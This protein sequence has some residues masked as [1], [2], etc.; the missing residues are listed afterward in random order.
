[1]KIVID[2]DIPFSDSMFAGRAEVVTAP[3]EK[4]SPELVKTADVLIVRS[5]TRVDERLLAGSSVAFVGTAT[6]GF[7][8]VDRAYLGRRGIAFAHAPGCNADSVAEYVV[9]AL[10]E[11]GERFHVRLRGTTIGI[12]GAGHVGRRVARKA[13]ALGMTVLLNDPPLAA[14][15]GGAGFLDLGDLMDADFVS[16]HVPLTKS[17]PHP[18]HHLFDRRRIA[19]MRPGSFLLNT[20]RGGVVETAALAGALR[21]G[22][23]PGAVLDVWEGEPSVDPEAV[24]LASIATAHIAGY[25]SDGKLRGAMM[26][27]EA[28]CDRAGWEKTWTAPPDALPPPARP[29][30]TVDNSRTDE[31]EVLRSLVASRYAIMRDDAELR[32]IIRLPQDERARYFVGLRNRYPPRREFSATTVACN[33]A[34]DSLSRAFSELGFSVRGPRIPSGKHKAKT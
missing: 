34:G 27:Y 12:V 23:L 11:I 18:T 20:A 10:L 22:G 3:G 29:E 19:S 31:Q 21:S 25:S 8:H 33:R 28:V 9:A 30:F 15:S 13:R 4:I 17:G 32:K 16:L 24:E 7:D 26:I 5:P 6:S 2:K 14:A 1:M